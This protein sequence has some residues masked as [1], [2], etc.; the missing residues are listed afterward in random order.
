[1]VGV[2]VGGVGWLC[3]WLV[4]VCVCCVGVD[5]EMYLR[6]IDLC[7]KHS[8]VGIFGWRSTIVK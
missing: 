8:Q 3:L 1:M 4:C 2:W 5:F 7:G 6:M